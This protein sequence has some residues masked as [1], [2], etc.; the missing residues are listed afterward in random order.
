MFSL[1]TQLLVLLPLFIFPIAY[2][3]S[4]PTLPIV[5]LGY[6][7]H[8]ASSFNVSAF[9]KKYCSPHISFVSPNYIHTAGGRS[10]QFFQH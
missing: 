7:L 8:Q 1:F 10:L 4:V 6:E 2:G 9:K 3:T 5:D